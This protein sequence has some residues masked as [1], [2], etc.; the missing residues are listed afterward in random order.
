MECD[1]V[2]VSTGV[3]NRAGSYC[4][5]SAWLQV[6]YIFLNFSVIFGSIDV[7]TILQISLVYL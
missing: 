5:D 2:I 4:L 1:D 7:I 6:V 3:A